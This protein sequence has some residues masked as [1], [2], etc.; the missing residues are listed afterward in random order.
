MFECFILYSSLSALENQK[1]INTLE[2]TI[3]LSIYLRK[4]KESWE[5]I[6]SILSDEWMNDNAYKN[7]LSRL[8]HDVYTSSTSRFRCIN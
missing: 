8:F 2:S 6:V 5:D 4:K 1:S 7:K 3:S